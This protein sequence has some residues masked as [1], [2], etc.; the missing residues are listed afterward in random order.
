MI[1]NYFKIAFRNLLKNKGYSAINIGGLAVGMAVTMLIGLWIYD[2]LSYDKYHQN[3][4][5]IGKIVLLGVFD[6]E[7]FH[8]EYMPAPMGEELRN[9]F[10]DDFKYVINSSWNGEHI[11]AFGDKKFTKTGNYL[12]EQAPDMFSLKM[13]KGTR[14]GLKEQSSIMLSES[15]ASA[16]FGKENPLD[17]IVKID[18]KLNVKVTGVYEDLPYNSEFRNLTFIAPWNLYVATQDWVKRALDNKEWDNNSWQVL[19]QINPNSDYAAVSKKIANLK[20]KHTPHTAFLKPRL[21]VE[22]MSNWHLYTGWDKSGNLDGRIQ[23]VWLFGIIGFF[24]LLL[25]SINFMNLST[26]RSEKRAK[27]VGIR[28]AI[29]S[30]RGQLISQF[31]S[32]S[33]LIVSLAFMLS[34]CLLI[35]SLPFFNQI[36]DK[37]MSVL[38]NS[39]V[40]WLLGIGFCLITGIISGSYPALYLSSFQP[41]KVLKGTFN[42]GRFAAIPR[43]VLVVLQFTVSVTLIIGTIIVFRQIQYAKNRPIGYDRSGLITVSMNTPELFNHYNDLRASL[44]E[45]GAVT[46]M[47]TSSSAVTEV[48]SNNSG[49]DWADKD[50]NF[51]PN[52]GTIAVSHDFGKTVGW[53]FKAGHDF[54][55][56]FS[57]DSTGLVLNETAV[58]YIGFKRP[59]D[60]LGKIIKWDNKPFTVIGVIRDMVMDSPF[61]PVDPTIF[62]LN[63][64]WANYINIKLNPEK[65]AAN[66][67]AKIE[68]VFRKF[69]PGS[70]F[71]YRFSDDQYAAKFASEE[72]I[73]KLASAFA[74]LAIL[75][76]CLGLFALASFT[77]EQ[78]TKEIGIRKVLGASVANLWAL[79]S[80]DFVVLVIIS[81]VVSV[82]IAYYFLNGWL[83]KYEYRTEISWWIFA[84]SGLG[85]MLITLL[86]VS[87]QAIR[88]ALMDPVKSLKSE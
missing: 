35:V 83:Q 4:D 69:N 63:Y 18:N 27:E 31:L 41:I 17:K 85:A 28:K 67:L 14:S 10:P 21:Y 56:Q 82:P 65:S 1:R 6:G 39:P 88:A 79:L 58:K 52:F 44:L 64:G 29:G 9:N 76:S 84:A 48:N 75:I 53:Q 60:I 23:Y 68:G 2:E 34:I 40:F 26:A 42:I 81:C 50:P 16:L 37:K 78:R 38:W 20:L 55:R 11:L 19:V 33:L 54:S 86:T 3:Y 36:A 87:Y 32:E 74:S 70:P 8:Q 43:K 62:M 51:K 73:A 66:S 72:R 59:E 49:F 57:T 15:V 25:A 30:K 12:S 46:E 61:K 22:P 47:S 45:T 80:A 5:R 13:L 77:A 24:V 71:D 7:V